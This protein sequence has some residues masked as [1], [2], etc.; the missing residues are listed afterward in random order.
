[1]DAA[2]NLHQVA[3]HYWMESDYFNDLSTRTGSVRAI[4]LPSVGLFSS[5]LTVDYLFGMPRRGSYVNRYM[6]VKQSLLGVTGGSAIDQ[7][8]FVE[9]AGMMGSFL[10]GAVFD[11]LF[12]RSAGNGISTAQ[13]L[14]DA[15]N[16]GDNI[17]RI[18]A[19]NIDNVLPLLSVD[20]SVTRDIRRAV[21]SG[22]VVVIPETQVD[23]SGWRGTGYLVQDSETG[24]GAYLISGGLNGGGEINCE[25]KSVPIVVY[26]LVA[27]VVA[28][29]I[30]W[31]WPII[32]AGLAGVGSGVA[33]GAKALVAAF[34]AL[35]VSSPAF[36]G[37]DAC[38]AEWEANR[39]WC[40]ATFKNPSNLRGCLDWANNMLRLCNAGCPTFPYYPPMD[41]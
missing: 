29:L 21:G 30:W 20:G 19:E 40:F 5:P 11:Q 27:V 35:L 15:A 38:I 16:A 34:A 41:E 6:D 22:K 4:R 17:Y 7:R 24:A 8:A 26:V 1:M 25:P 18:T 9:S 37:G 36:A 2:E 39:D 12:A 32:A 28:L 31:L 3:L 10:E 14:V 23:L 13:L 33:L